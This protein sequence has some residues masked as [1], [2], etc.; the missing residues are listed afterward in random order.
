MIISIAFFTAILLAFSC[1]RFIIQLFYLV[2]LI[3]MKREDMSR[4]EIKLLAPHL[5]VVAEDAK[6]AAVLKGS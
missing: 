1:K 5:R 2:L 4:E 6:K 3:K